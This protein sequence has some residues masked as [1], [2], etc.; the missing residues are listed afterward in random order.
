MVTPGRARV[1][2]PL[3][4]LG[5]GDAKLARLGFNAKGLPI[6]FM[7]MKMKNILSYLSL[8]SFP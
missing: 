8:T 4:G 7:K 2:D 6:M 3:A 1:G 5:H